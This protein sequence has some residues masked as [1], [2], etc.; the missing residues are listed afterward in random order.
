MRVRRAQGRRWEDIFEVLQDH[1][2]LAHDP[3]VVN[4]RRHD[5]ARI[6]LEIVGIVLLS[7]VQARIDVA[8]FPLQ[9]LF[10]ERQADL[11][12]G[13][14]AVEVIERDHA[15]TW[16]S[17]GSLRT[18]TRSTLAQDER[19]RNADDWR[20]TPAM[21]G[22]NRMRCSASPVSASSGLSAPGGSVE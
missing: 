13:G 1:L 14:R 15:C 19:N 7:L 5:A 4:E 18:S 6:E 21:C 16:L 2:R 10:G 8:A 17:G 9:A 11:L 3:A 22:V 12:R 20:V